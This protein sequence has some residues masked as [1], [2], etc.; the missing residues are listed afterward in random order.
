[1]RNKYRGYRKSLT[2]MVRVDSE[3]HT[4][5]GVMRLVRE[6][7]VLQSVAQQDDAFGTRAPWRGGPNTRLE[8]NL[9]DG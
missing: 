2:L 9:R 7:G 4:D 3:K 6:D 5:I 1:M 8:D